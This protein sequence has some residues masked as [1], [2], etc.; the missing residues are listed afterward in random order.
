MNLRS[1]QSPAEELRRSMPTQLVLSVGTLVE[2]VRGPAAELPPVPEMEIFVTGSNLPQALA[3]EARRVLGP[4]LN[5]FYATTEMSGIAMGSTALLEQHDGTAGVLFPGVEVDAVD[6]SGRPLP[7]GSVGILRMRSEGMVSG[8]LTEDPADRAA[9]E[10]PFRNGWFYPG[11]LGS[12]SA[13]GIVTVA[14]RAIEVMNIA[15]NKFQPTAIEEVALS[16]AGIREAAAFSVPDENGVETPW[17]AVV[18]DADHR[19]GEVARAIKARWPLMAG[20][21]V[22]AGREIPR[23]QMGKIDRLRLRQQ[24]LAWKA[25]AA[26]G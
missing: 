6:G 22:A 20:L 19:P 5:V 26:R 24:A 13:D 18:R 2:L 23:N 21:Q 15:G 11:D 16:C 3:D 1:S 17:I 7:N 12:V 10:S 9:G 8:Y 14:G 4:N 25:G